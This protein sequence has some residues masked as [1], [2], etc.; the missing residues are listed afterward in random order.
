MLI[1]FG[2]FYS[3]HKYPSE[4]EIELQVEIRSRCPKLRFM[5]MLRIMHV[6]ITK[7]ALSDR[8]RN[9]LYLLGRCLKICEAVSAGDDSR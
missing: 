6:R 5:E 3:D 7:R 4:M 2:Y 1:Y 8:K 9:I